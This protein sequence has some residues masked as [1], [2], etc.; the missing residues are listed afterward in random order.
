[1]NIIILF[2]IE[3]NQEGKIIVL[4]GDRLF[5]SRTGRAVYNSCLY[6]SKPLHLAT[7]G[8]YIWEIIRFWPTGIYEPS[9]VKSGTLKIWLNVTAHKNGITACPVHIFM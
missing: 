6:R 5:G 3:F 4:R 8:Y 2:W 7:K 1:M 9:D